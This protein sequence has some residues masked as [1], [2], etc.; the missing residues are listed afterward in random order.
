[1]ATRRR[2]REMDLWKIFLQLGILVAGI[3]ICSTLL[4]SNWGKE[5]APT[6]TTPPTDTEPPVTTT[7]PEPTIPPDTSP[8]GILTSF[9]EEHN[10]TE[11]DYTERQMKAY[12]F[13]PE[14]RDFILNIP[15]E[16]DKEHVADITGT[17]R[18]TVPLFLQWDARWGYHEYAY[19]VGG[20]TGCGPTCLSM[21]AYY[22][23][24]NTD[25][26]PQYMMDFSMEEKC[27]GSAGGTNW[28]LFTTAAPKLGLEVKELP[29]YKS[30]M[31]RN[32]EAGNPIVVNVKKG[33]F[34][35]DG[36]YIVLTGYSD[37]YFTVNDPN[38]V[39]NS[40]KGWTY[41]Q[42]EGQIKNLWVVSLPTEE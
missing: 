19:D 4:W 8:S 36:H 39:A 12:E 40:E 9:M 14:A 20:V 22:L 18:T 35:Q 5:K 23:T 24:G 7:E 2:R 27:V 10:L 25:Y 34:T 16:K 13:C 17:D 33:D 1:M 31:V 38:S 30:I 3:V 28:T 6:Q 21:V 41:E 37:G 11:E 42:L 32:L 15:L 26:T 29:L